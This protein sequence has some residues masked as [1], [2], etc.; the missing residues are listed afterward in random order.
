M[1]TDPGARGA[2]RPAPGAASGRLD[3][4]DQEGRA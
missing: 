3:A 4:H 2:P 1:L